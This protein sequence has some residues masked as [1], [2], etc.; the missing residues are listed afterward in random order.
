MNLIQ[1]QVSNSLWTLWHLQKIKINYAVSSLNVFD[2]KIFHRWPRSFTVVFERNHCKGQGHPWLKQRWLCHQEMLVSWFA[3]EVWNVWM[4]QEGAWL[5]RSQE[6]IFIL[7]WSVWDH[8]K[9]KTLQFRIF[10]ERNK[11]KRISKVRYSWIW[12]RTDLSHKGWQL[13]F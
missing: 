11:T 5:T 7:V 1:K 2:F 9:F 10:K 3:F 6:H 4:Q 13:K 8:L 12:F